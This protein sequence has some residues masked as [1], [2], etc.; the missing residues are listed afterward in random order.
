MDLTCPACQKR[1][2]IPDNKLPTGHAV[3]ITCPACQQR[4]PYDP[5]AHRTPGGTVVDTGLAPQIGMVSMPQRALTADANTMQALVCLDGPEHQEVCQQMLQSLGYTADTMPNQFK[6]LEYL[7]E[8][9]YRLFVLDAAFD[10]TSLDTNLVLTFLRERPL[11]QR[12]YQFVV[13][14]APELP[15][16]DPMTA[17]SQS[18]NLVLNHADMPTCGAMLAQQLAEHDL[19]YRTFREMRQQLGKEV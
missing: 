16:A 12:R 19:L 11:D 7:R 17:Y 5:R 3:R 1:L 13:L 4:F 8:V 2:Q 10:G 6:A 9:P 15:T 14:C 18:V